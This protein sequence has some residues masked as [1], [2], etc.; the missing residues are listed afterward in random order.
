MVDV[1]T[2]HV[3]G[4]I[5]PNGPTSRLALTR[6]QRTLYATGPS[7]AFMTVIDLPN[8]KATAR[9]EVGRGACCIMVDD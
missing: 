4:Y 8:R 3:A 2:H 9:I 7:D 5:R 1:P 6:D